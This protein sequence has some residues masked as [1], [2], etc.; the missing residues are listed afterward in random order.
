MTLTA[1]ATADTDPWTVA[2][3]DLAAGT[4]AAPGSAL[5]DGDSFVTIPP[6][7]TGGR[8]RLTAP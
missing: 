7:E 1:S 8:S 6:P 5:R 4:G 3:V 2:T